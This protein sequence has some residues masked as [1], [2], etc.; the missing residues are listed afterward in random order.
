MASNLTKRLD[1]LERLIRE[2]TQLD[3]SPLYLR[4]GQTI[5]EDIDPDRVI[6]IK[7]E[8]ADPPE[9]E[10]EEL[11]VLAPSLPERTEPENFSRPLHWPGGHSLARGSD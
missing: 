5:P 8:Y 3:T 1:R 10:E 9:R 4:E 7:R 2:R 11:P 6:H